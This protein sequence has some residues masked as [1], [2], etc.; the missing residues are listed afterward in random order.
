MSKRIALVTGATQG[1]GLALV[2]G[3]AQRLE[4]DDVAYPTAVTK[5]GWKSPRMC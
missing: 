2:A 1:L 4:P 5:R 3:L